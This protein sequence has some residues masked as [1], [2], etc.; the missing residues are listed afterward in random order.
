[1]IDTKKEHIAVTEANRLKIPVVAVVDTN[2][3]PDIIDYVIPG[4][5]DAIRV[6]QLMCRVI[7]DAVNEG[8]RDAAAAQ[9]AAGHPL[10]RRG[11]G[12]P[13]A[14]PA[15]T[16][17]PEQEKEFQE[18]QQAQAKAPRPREQTRDR[19]AGPPGEGNEGR[20]R[21]RTTAT[22]SGERRRPTRPRT[23]ALTYPR[24]RSTDTP[25]T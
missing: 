1:M 8:Q 12:A 20:G 19:G 11:A 7:A 21:R 24:R 9:R 2:C 14:A 13:A 10:R 25:A 3:D 5:D 22:G 4:N 6:G 23:P 18:K 17:T 16:R 15:R